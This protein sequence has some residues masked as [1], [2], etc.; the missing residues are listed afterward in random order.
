MSYKYFIINAL[1]LTCTWLLEWKY[2]PLNSHLPP[3]TRNPLKHI[4]IQA[5]EKEKMRW[6]REQG[7]I[8]MV[9]G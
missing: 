5:T 1:S 6:R 8:K 2:E 3:S 4:I 9:Q 7:H